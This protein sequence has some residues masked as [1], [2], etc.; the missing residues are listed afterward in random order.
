[1][2]D[3]LSAAGQ[4][5]IVPL[6][7]WNCAKNLPHLPQ[8]YVLIV[9]LWNWNLDVSNFDTSKVSFNRTFMELKCSTALCCDANR[10]F[11]RTFMELKL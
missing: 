5:L 8:A 9:P 10:S 11:N 1:M 3:Y 7:N 4:V 2:P 6:W